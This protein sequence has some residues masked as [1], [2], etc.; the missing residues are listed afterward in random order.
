MTRAAYQT[1]TE[2]G[3]A[4]LQLIDEWQL[5]SNGETLTH[6][7]TIVSKTTVYDQASNVARLPGDKAVYK[8]ISK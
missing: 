3:T 1:S 2:V 4:E 6:T 7:H 5:S 8:L